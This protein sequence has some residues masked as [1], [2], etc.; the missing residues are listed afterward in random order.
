LSKLPQPTVLMLESLG[1][2]DVRKSATGEEMKKNL[3]KLI[4]DAHGRLIIGTFS[5]QVERIS[6]IIELA[7]K[8][9]KKVALD[10]YSMKVN[11]EIAQKLGYIKARPG[12]II[13]VEQI[14]NVP[15]NKLIVLCTGAQG[16]GN[17]VLSRIIEG[18]H[19]FVKIKKSDTVILS[20]SI[21]PGNERTIQ[22]LKDNL[23]RLC[24]NVIHGSIMDIHVSGHGNR[25]DIITMLKTIRPSYFIPVYANHYMLKEAAKLARDLGMR[26]ERIMVPDNGQVIEFD[27]RGGRMT[28][29][30]VPADYIFVDGLGITDSNN[31][32]LRDRQMMAEDGMLV[33]IATI[34]G[35]TGE[36]IHNPDLISR[37]FVYMK[38]NKKLIEMTRQKVKKLLKDNNPKTA[39]DDQYLKEMIRNE[40]GKFLYQK[41][42]KR[43]MILPV[44]IE[45]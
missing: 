9:N 3:T 5:S 20:S 10:G 35:K 39:P 15:D 12:T 16:E 11:I 23:Y 4:T 7:Q 14:D 8:L 34:N 26:P 32:V 43:P 41:T 28:D 18:S 37:G 2:I 33:V 24:D 45:V 40:I 17:A 42:E 44:I 22:R 29:K 27:R 36:L 6:W 21:I 30:K 31:V 38:E 25:E 19:R 1:A 13:K